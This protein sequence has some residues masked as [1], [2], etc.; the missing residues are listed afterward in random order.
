MRMAPKGVQ[1]RRLMAMAGG[2][3]D[4]SGVLAALLGECEGRTAPRT[5]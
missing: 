3:A 4:T 2:D 5:T 1:L